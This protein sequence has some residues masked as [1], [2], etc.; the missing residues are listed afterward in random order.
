M[1]ISIEGHELEFD[2]ELIRSYEYRTC[3]DFATSA[4][5]RLATNFQEADID[6]IFREHTEQEIKNMIVKTAL[7]E[8][9]LYTGG[10]GSGCTKTPDFGINDAV[11]FLWK[12]EIK[13]GFVKI[14]DEYGTFEQWEEPSYD[15]LVPGEGLYKHI[16]ES[17]IRTHR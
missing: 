1:L 13:R 6:K 8:I 2:D 9:D 3:A 5:T 17:L 7:M 15:I 11:E 16:R 12:N 14:V 10:S 4:E